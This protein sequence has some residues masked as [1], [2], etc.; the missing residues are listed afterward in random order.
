M[1]RRMVEGRGMNV[2]RMNFFSHGSHADHAERIARVRAATKLPM[3]RS[4]RDF[5]RSKIRTGFCWPDHAPVLLQDG[6]SFDY[7]SAD[8][9][10]AQVVSTNYRTLAEDVH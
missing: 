1:I 8:R 9:G 3:W 5:A 10:T 2:A 4:A 7:R 6:A